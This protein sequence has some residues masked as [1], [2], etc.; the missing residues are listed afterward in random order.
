MLATA[1]T[2]AAATAAL[3]AGTAL[4]EVLLAAVLLDLPVQMQPAHRPSAATL[5]VEPRDNV[6]PAIFMA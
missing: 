1:A 3:E 4:G 6:L 2:G 5:I